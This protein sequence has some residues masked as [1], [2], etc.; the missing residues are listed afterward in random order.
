[1]QNTVKDIR[2]TFVQK[3]LHDE[4][5]TD[6]TGVKTI[7]IVGA[8]FLAD[9]VAI[10]GT[11]DQNYIDR[12]IQWYESQSCNVNDLAPTPKIWQEISDKNGMIHSNYGYLIFSAEN[13]HQYKRCRE[14]LSLN[15]NTRR[16]VMIYTRPTMH[17]EYN[18]NGM[19]DFICTNAVQYLIRDNTLHAIVQMR[20]NDVVFGYRN[21]SAWQEYVLNKLANDLGIP[22]GGI[23]WQV[24]SLHV[25]E[26]HFKHIED[27]IKTINDITNVADKCF[28]NSFLPTLDANAARDWAH[29]VS[30]FYD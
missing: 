2:E 1:M 5:V 13:K 14:H 25:Y 23:T 7:E 19:S 22:P 29:Q 4:F 28:G 17:T 12:E 11:P 20:S 15:P 27:Y 16:A 6:K 30:K 3:F 21:D 8:S 10:F 9:K 18:L 24:G 26:R